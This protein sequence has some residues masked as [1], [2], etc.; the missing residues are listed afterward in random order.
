ML[1]LG[2]DVERDAV[3]AHP[4]PHADA[5]RGDLVLDLEALVGPAHPDADPVLAPLTLDVEAREAADQPFLERRDEGTH[6][7]AAPLQ[8]EHDIGNALAGAVIGELPA[9]AGAEH[10]E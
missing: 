5:D 8:V 6:V 4:A 3:K 10:R 1:E 9:A 7:R 2:L